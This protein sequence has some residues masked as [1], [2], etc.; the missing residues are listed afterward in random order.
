[1]IVQAR[2]DGGV[3]RIAISAAATFICPR[4]VNEDWDGYAFDRVRSWAVY[5]GALV[6]A[7]LLLKFENIDCSRD[8]WRKLQWTAAP[9]F[10]RM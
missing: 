3:E 10:K 8:G 5:D 7:V 9:L 2:F 4:G 6:R 1:M